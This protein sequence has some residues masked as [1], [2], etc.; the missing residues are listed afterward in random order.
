MKENHQNVLQLKREVL[1][2]NSI[3]K[4][5]IRQASRLLQAKIQIYFRI[6]LEGETH[7]IEAI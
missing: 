4:S 7:I 1:A 3:M 2:G 5:T 6:A